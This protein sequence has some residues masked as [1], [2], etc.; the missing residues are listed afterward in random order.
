MPLTIRSNFDRADRAQRSLK[1]QYDEE[2]TQT[3]MTD[4]ICDLHHLADNQGIDFEDVLRMVEDH[5]EAE[6]DEERL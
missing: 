5:H 3:N 6:I 2:D 1:Y 4:L